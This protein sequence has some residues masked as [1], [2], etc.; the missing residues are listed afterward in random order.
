MGECVYGNVNHGTLSNA[1]RP[2]SN[3]FVFEWREP[4][5]TGS[6]V[7]TLR[8]GLAKLLRLLDLDGGEGAI[9]LDRMPAM[10]SSAVSVSVLVWGY[11]RAGT[12]SVRRGRTSVDRDSEP[13]L[14]IR[15]GNMRKFQAAQGEKGCLCIASGS[16]SQRAGGC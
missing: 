9:L 14:D 4:V 10:N 12:H 16:C 8:V 15:R 1:R 11:Q 13:I 3:E 6:L 5:D 7:V 2:N